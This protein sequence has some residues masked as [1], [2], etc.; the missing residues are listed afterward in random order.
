MISFLF[1]KIPY[2]DIILI[3]MEY[4]MIHIVSSRLPI[5]VKD[6]QVVPSNGGLV[7]LW[8]NH[9]KIKILPKLENG[10]R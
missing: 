8:N 2:I 1:E 5:V 4:S 7:R 9:Q 10:L 3:F 6:G